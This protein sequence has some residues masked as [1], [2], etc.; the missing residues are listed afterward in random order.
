MR[1]IAFVVGVLVMVGFNTYNQYMMDK[2][3][4][5]QEL[6][7]KTEIDKIFQSYK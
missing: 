7:W 5:E 1:V 4:K 2:C 6:Y 3:L